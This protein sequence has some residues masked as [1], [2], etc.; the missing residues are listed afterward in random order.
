MCWYQRICLY[1]LVLILG[2]ALLSEDKN[3]SKYSMPLILV[4]LGISVY[5]NLYYYDLIPK[6][7]VPCNA[8]VSCSAKQLELF[9]F[10]T[11]P[12]LAL[13]NFIIMSFVSILVYRKGKA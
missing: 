3:H 13:C 7:I 2:A 12:L 10:I 5:H 11:V 6:E 8:E 4:G 9:G 1:P